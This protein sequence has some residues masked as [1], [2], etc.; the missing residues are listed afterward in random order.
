MDL[1]VPLRSLIPTL[2]A[3][4]LTVLAGTTAPLTGR[5]VAELAARGSQPGV[6]R[7]L[8]RLVGHGLV[9]AQPAGA[10]R[11]YVLNREH[12]L[13]GAVLEA[14]ATRRRLRDRLRD[15]IADWQVA[16]EHASLFGSVARGDAGPRSDIDVLVVRPDDVPADSQHWQ[17]QLG[18]L[19][20]DV[21][22]WTGNAL[23]VFETSP[24]DLARAVDAE[25]PLL[26]SLK[27]EGLHLAGRRLH[28][29]LEGVAG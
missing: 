13:A 2:E 26:Q 7:V 28:M 5:R 8:D 15:R 3:E 6:Q 25:E 27:N 19:E 12:L 10:A 29:L 23:A 11:L 21:A 16:C 17:R 4:V 20:E 18:A 24:A 14:T 1:A 22:L 9:T